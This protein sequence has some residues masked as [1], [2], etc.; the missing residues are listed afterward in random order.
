[1]SGTFTTL[2]NFDATNNSPEGDLVDISGTLYGTGNNGG[3]SGFGTLFSFSTASGTWNVLY[4]FS[5]AI[6]GST[7]GAAP[8]SGLVDVGGTLYG[9]TFNGGSASSYGTL[10]SYDPGSGQEQ[11]LVSFNANDGAN[12]HGAVIDVGGILYGTTQS[13]GA[14]TS[15]GTL[16]AY[17]VA[18]AKL[19]TLFS[20]DNTDGA[21]PVGSLIDVSGTLYGTTNYGGTSGDGTLFAYDLA[22]GTLETLANFNGTNGHSPYGGV[23]DVNGTLYGTTISGGTAD[24][25]TL[26]A[27]NIAA[28]TL[29][30]LASFTGPSGGGPAAGLLD[31]NGTLYGTT[32][33]DGT[34]GDGSLFAYNIAG[35][36][37]Q[38][39][40]TFNGNNGSVP[41]GGLID[42]N[43]TLYGTTSSG[44]SATDGTLFSY[45]LAC[46]AEGTEIL[47][48]CGEVPVEDLAVGVRVATLSGRLARIAWLGHRTVEPQRHPRPYDVNPIRVHADAF[49]KNLPAG[50]LILSPDHAVL[51]DGSL[52]PIRH[53]A[54]GTSIAQEPRTRITYWHVELD[55]HDAI[56]AEGLACETYLDTGNRDAFAG[57]AATRLHPDFAQNHAARIWA[58]RG[59]APILTEPAAPALR[60]LHTGLLA[61]AARAA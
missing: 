2:A 55:R 49:G 6:G 33:N 24:A 11:V 3:T 8:T 52:I 17:D 45:T 58:E 20:F 34:A 22:A 51:V 16:F 18:T 59:C 60:H 46:F 41:I 38:T 56:L 36:S 26:F 27:Y 54:N 25:G 14:G 39:L 7:D 61:K 44:G 5:G 28:G 40:V 15:Y 32:I 29:D 37:L 30:A 43:G 35:N 1:M 21:T 19:Q 42:I 57:E 4:N 10:F 53:L 47:T 31:V 9:T 23:I 48:E 12:P 13:G 50:D